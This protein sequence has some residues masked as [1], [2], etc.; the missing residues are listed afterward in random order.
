M[1]W[2]A[3]VSK[4]VSQMVQGIENLEQHIYITKRSAGWLAYKNHTEL[5]NSKVCIKLALACL[6]FLI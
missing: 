2:M 5:V 3:P 6:P 4:A 1:P